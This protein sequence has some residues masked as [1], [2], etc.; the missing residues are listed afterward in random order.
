[1]NTVC[2]LRRFWVVGLVWLA[3]VGA[4]AQETWDETGPDW[5]IPEIPD[6]AEV[7]PALSRARK[8]VKATALEMGATEAEAVSVRWMPEDES[9]TWTVIDSVDQ[10]FS[11]GSAMREVRATLPPAGEVPSSALPVSIHQSELEYYSQFEADGENEWDA[12]KDLQS[13]T[14]PLK[15]FALPKGGASS[16]GPFVLGKE[17]FGWHPYWEGSGYTNYT[18]DLLSTVAYF[19]Y[20]VNPSTGY[21]TTMNSWSNTPLVQW[22]HSNGTKVV[23]CAT[24]MS[25]HTNFFASA[26]AQSNLIGELIRVV[27]LRDA[28]G[29]NIDFEAIP[30]GYR[31]HLTTFMSNLATRMHAEIPGSQVS[32][33]LPAVDWSSLF[34][35]AAYN[36]FLDLCIIMGYDYSWS[37]DTQAGPVAP[38][39]GSATFGTYCEQRSISNYLAAGI[40][41]GKLLLG[42]PYY[43]YDWP[44]VSHALHANTTGSGTAR[45]YPVAKSYA[46][47]YGYNWDSNSQTPYVL[48]GSYRQLWYDDTNS[49]ALKYDFANSK[50]LAGIGIWALNYDEGTSDLWDLLAEKFATTDSTWITQTSG[51]TTNFYGVGAK[52]SSFAA[53]GAG[54]AIYT[55]ADNGVTWTPRTSGTTSLLL[56]FTSG[57]GMWVAV[58]DLG[59]IVTSVGGATWTVRSTP[60]NAMLRGIAYGD[61]G[62]VFVAVGAAGTILRSTD[63][64]A[65]NWTQVVSGTAENLQG[66][67]YVGNLF[68]ATGENSVLLTSSDGASW[69][70]RASNASGWLLDAAYG[71]GTYVAVGLGGRVV[72]SPDGVVWT[73]QT[74]GLPNLTDNLYRVA[75]GNGQFVAVGQ[76]GVI[77]G[78]PNGVDWT[79]ENSG[80]TDFL[81]GVVYSNDLF[82]AAGYNGTILTKG[83][84]AP[85]IEITTSGATVP[86][87]TSSQTVSGT[88]NAYV[89]GTMR[90]TN[91]LG[92][93]GTVAAAVNWSFSA[94]LALGTN[95]VTVTA[96]NAAGASSSDSVAF[97]RE[98]AEEGGGS[99]AETTPASQPSGGLSD[100]IVYT[101]AGHGACGDTGS[102]IFGRALVNGIVEDIG[103]IDQLNYF[104]DYCFKAGAT[105]VPMRPLGQQT[106]EVVLDN[107]HTA[108]V[109]FGGTWYDS[110]STIF[111]GAA[112]ATPYRYA[113]INETGTTAW[114]IYRP[115]LPAAGF[116]PVYAWTRSGSDRV[117]QL[118][119]VYH[120]GGVT[121][122]RVNHRRVGLGWV[123][124]GTYYFEAG[125]NGSVN[126]SNY[127]PGGYLS[128]DVVIADAIRF[129]NG[130][131]DIDRGSGVSGL[132]RE[133]EGSR[134]WVQAMTGQ[135]MSTTLYDGSYAD[136]SDNVGAPT[137]MA[138]EMNRYDTNDVATGT[139]W[140]RIYLGFHS[141]AGGGTA[142]GPIGLYN[143]YLASATD[144]NRQKDLAL[145][146]VSRLTNGLS[147]GDGGVWFPDVFG[148]NR[149]SPYLGGAYGEI[150]NS[151]LNAEMNST[152]IEV[153]FHDNTDDAYLLKDPAA[154]QVMAMSCY[155]G[156]VKHLTTNN[157]TVVSPVLL[158][159]P[160]THVSAVN[161]GAGNVTLNWR[162]PVTNGYSGDAATGYIIYRS[163]N[164]YGFGNPVAVSGGAT[165]SATLTNMTLGQITYFQVC[166]TNRGGESLASRT[167][168]VRVSPSGFAPHLVVNGFERNERRISPTNYI[169]KNISDYVTRVIQRK[170]NSQDYVIQHGE[171]IAAAGRYFD[172]CDNES[173]ADGDVNLTDYYAAYWILGRESTA[174]ETF[175]SAEQ[176]EVS[177]FL[178]AGNCLFASGTE[179]GWDLQYSGTAADKSFC[180]NVLKT[181][182]VSA[183]DDS[184]TGFV[185]TKSAGIF[186]GVGAIAFDY[187]GTGTTYKASYPD[188]L[189][190]AG[191]PASVTA[192]VY[193]ASSAG[194]NVAALAY[195]NA[196]RLIVMGF[197]FET[198]HSASTRTN[199]MARTLSFFG[200]A[201]ADAPVVDITTV[202]QTLAAGTT[203]LSI[204]GTNNAAVAGNLTWSNVWTGASGSFAAS[205]SWSVAVSLATGTNLIRVTG[206][207]YLLSQTDEDTVTLTVS[208]PAVVSSALSVTLAPAATVSAGAQWRVDGGAWRASGATATGLTAGAHTVSFSTVSGWTAPADVATATTN[209]TTNA[210]TATYIEESSGPVTIF[211]DDFE[212]G[213]LVGWTQDGA[214]NW[215]NS[216]DTPITGSRSLKHNLSGV[217]TTNYVY[218]QPSYSLSADTTTWRFKLKNGNWDPSSANRFHVFLAASDADFT[219]SAVDG[220]AVGINLTGLDDL[221]KLCRVTDG[222]LDSV[223]LASAVD[224]DA[225]TTVAV[226]VTRTAAGLWELK[227]STAGVF[228]GMTSAGTAS[229]TTYA[230]TSYFGLYFLCSSTRAGQVWLDDVLIHQGELS[231]ATDSDGDGMPDDYENTYFG[232]ATSGDPDADDDDDGMSNLAE[233]VAGTH[234][235]QGTSVLAFDPLATNQ[236]A[237]ANLIFRWP[238]VSGR[239]YAIWR[240]TNAMGPYTQHIGGITADIPTNT[241]TNAAPT[242][243]G[244]YFYGLKVEME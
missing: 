162:A 135:G 231:G 99:G 193:G 82:M 31:T 72:T 98:P 243:L 232:G 33:C 55:S 219:G 70:A 107:T 183:G 106:N 18:F 34:D 203:L 167:V 236:T 21:A 163:T 161:D 212:D 207:N 50:G 53:V 29:V 44:T 83:A 202:N 58:G 64:N 184:G 174:D 48:Y 240:A 239:V 152:I 142:Q 74:N 228:S 78:S 129:G 115:N 233:Y 90:W 24:M 1:M 43:G 195:S 197:P 71:N 94:A 126:I 104:A 108:C 103:N 225:L 6:A 127:A 181:A 22:A 41:P 109:M 131:G 215:A 37:T 30:S 39:T 221:L 26:A 56:N 57:S 220:Y 69:T 160:P 230:D 124:L 149:S 20:E 190:V 128:T 49:L 120:S 179:I 68:I 201:P 12:I 2:G 117:K 10:E 216:T 96:T 156:I 150:S 206:N 36:G 148:Y 40:S 169:G 102:W 154:R 198:I 89:V 143:S 178:A 25:G 155:Q 185:S 75:F 11:E 187:A 112:G 182:F 113:Y 13:K 7:P 110:T 164:G 218:A 42:V 199:L 76:N 144:Q 204:S 52:A 235:G 168:G 105:V 241:V 19:S 84:G 54:G 140:D 227:T 125:T 175:S 224:W 114:A 93:S 165:L 210:F 15:T 77:W 23:L 122:V 186:D 138:G 200:D 87:G 191:S 234:P 8:L 214:G 17:V 159:D 32:I 157:P 35:V 244:T 16:P 85:A 95:V 28:D 67:N 65:S 132:A 208:A 223:V 242:G 119:R 66:V 111:Y 237:T 205:S 38:L 45:M 46:A 196:N 229:D 118:Y 194:T 100:I 60:T 3:A 151:V 5:L 123:W 158:P 189:K 145:M 101:S 97:I 14:L 27:N 177:N 81:R 180:S 133:L 147:Y 139:I 134:Y 121:D 141:N 88:A 4:P 130:M 116:Y 73:R 80:T 153:A 47:T 166:A 59:T 62:D 79:A 92:G 170:I 91:S 171:A 209:G 86:N 176:T 51:T 146:L 213:D 137:R 192:L 226:E 9:V 61:A 172:S 188:I 173:V 211:E 63:G 136:V 238:S 222:A 217:A